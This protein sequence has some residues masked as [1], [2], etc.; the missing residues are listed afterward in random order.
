MPPQKTFAL[1]LIAVI[2]AQLVVAVFTSHWLHRHIFSTEQDLGHAMKRMSS[3]SPRASLLVKL[4]Y[5]LILLEFAVAV[6]AKMLL[7]R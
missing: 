6:L 7:Y 4:M 1:I 2:F 5:V 3:E